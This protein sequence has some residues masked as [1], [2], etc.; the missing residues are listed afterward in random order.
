MNTVQVQCY[1]KKLNEYDRDRRL[2][3]ARLH[4]YELGAPLSEN[5]LSEL[6]GKFDFSI[7]PDYRLFLREV[8]NK[9]AGPFLG[10]EDVRD[11]LHQFLNSNWIFP[12]ASEADCDAVDRFLDKSELE[13]IDSLLEMPGFISICEYGCGYFEGLVVS[14]PSR[15]QIWRTDSGNNFV[16]VAD[17]F[18]KWYQ[19]WLE[20]GLSKFGAMKTDVNYFFCYDKSL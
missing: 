1:L 6:E 17:S 14:G 13:S 16:P 2:F 15:G 7:P 4:K 8:G 10:L 11:C 19:D 9:G 12:F 3:G 20:E 18:C 5:D